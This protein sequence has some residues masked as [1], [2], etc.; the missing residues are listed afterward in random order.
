[1]P[2][3]K[4]EEPTVDS[5]PVYES[6]LGF[7]AVEDERFIDGVPVVLPPEAI[8]AEYVTVVKSSL[9]DSKKL[10]FFALMFAFLGAASGMAGG[11]AL[12]KPVLQHIEGLPG[13][14][15]I[16]GE[17]GVAGEQGSQGIKGDKGNTGDT[18]LQGPAG[19]MGVVS[20]LDNIPG[21]PKNCDAPTVKTVTVQINGADSN[22][23]VISCN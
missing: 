15:G 16:Q 3:K 8:K 21:W 13:P 2:R 17:Q 9:M 14:Q 23:Q 20:S 7:S 12:A 18:G 19:P 11:I 22:I 10:F 6:E 4:A 1:M 5:T